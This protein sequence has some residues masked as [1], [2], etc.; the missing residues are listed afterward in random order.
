MGETIQQYVPRHSHIL[1][2]VYR[3]VLGGILHIEA[4]GNHIIILNA[5]E[6]A[7]ELLEKRASNSSDRPV[8]PILELY[9]RLPYNG[10]DNKILILQYLN[11]SMGWTNMVSLLRHDDKWRLHRRICQQNFRKAEAHKYHP[12]QVRKVHEMLQG[13]LE[14]PQ[15]FDDHN[16]MWYR[17][18]F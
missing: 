2:I 4:L 16:K 12:L 11:Y 5:V 8:I 1:W 6:D 18:W 7:D 9:V 14:T 3:C 17:L 10:V 15:D 13:L